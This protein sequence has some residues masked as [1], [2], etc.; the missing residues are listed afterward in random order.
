MVSC[1]KTVSDTG[2]F[3]SENCQHLPLDRVFKDH[4]ADVRNPLSG[5]GKKRNRKHKGGSINYILDV[6]KN[7]IGGLTEVARHTTQPIYVDGKTLP[8]KDMCGGKRKVKNSDGKKS[9]KSKNHKK[10]KKEKKAKKS[11]KDKK[12]K[13]SKKSQKNKK[14]KKA[15]KSKKENN[16]N[17][18]NNQ[19]TNNNQNTMNNE[20]TMN[21]KIL[22]KIENNNNNMNGGN[23]DKVG[24]VQES[25]Y[26][27]NM[28]E[29]TFGCRQPFWDSKCT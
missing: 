4:F 7:P 5:G 19:N 10:S 3:K 17:K 11:K 8:G 6:S 27:A 9:G 23:N 25:T 24:L 15:K 14:A 29:R 18:M 26:T 21:K 16:N 1:T 22:K 20:N 2:A 13:K 28:N 12:A